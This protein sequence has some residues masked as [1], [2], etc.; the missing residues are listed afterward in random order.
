MRV[1][2]ARASWWAVVLTA[3]FA[4]AGS[5]FCD[6]SVGENHALIIGVGAYE[7]WTN[8]ES[9]PKEAR[10]LADLLTRK[11]NFKK[12]NVLL[13]TDGTENLPTRNRISQA[14]GHYLQ[15]MGPK[16]NLLVFF[17]GRS[18]TN[19]TGQTYW[20]P[21]DA[22]TTSTLNWL[23][24]A[25]LVNEYF[26]SPRFAAKNVLIITDSP[27]SAEL[28]QKGDNPLSVLNL[29][30]GERV[31]E[32]ASRK[33]REVIASGI[34]H[35]DGASSPDGMSP[36]VRALLASLAENTLEVA[37]LENLLFAPAG[38]G[39]ETAQVP[40]VRGRLKTAA[41]AGGQF[42]VINAGLYPTVDVVR[43][44][45]HP[46]EGFPGTVFVFKAET[47]KP[48]RSVAL[49]INGQSIPMKG[50]GTLWTL[51]TPIEEIQETT[52]TARALNRLDRPGQ[53][54]EALLKVVK[55]PANVIEIVNLQVSPDKV[56]P[57]GE[58]MVTITTRSPA[59][60]LALTVDGKPVDAQGGGMDW[61]ARIK[62]DKAGKKEILARAVNEDGLE[63]PLARTDLTVSAPLVHVQKVAIRPSTGTVGKPVTISARTDKP[64]SRVV[65]WIN[66]RQADM[67]GSGTSWKYSFVPFRA[68][69]ASVRVAAANAG[70]EWGQEKTTRFSARRAYTP[71]SVTQVRAEPSPAYA[72]DPVNV[73]ANTSS[74]ASRVTVTVDGRTLD[75][76]GGPTRW[77]Q[78]VILPAPGT[79]K[80]TFKA[81]GKGGR[82]GAP[83]TLS[84]VVEKKSLGE[85]MISSV[86]V[87]PRKVP[88]GKPV[89]FVMITNRP[90]QAA[91]IS[92]DGGAPV[93]MA[94][95]NGTIWTLDRAFD[96]LGTKSYVITAVDENGE[97]AAP[98]DGALL[99]KA[100]LVQITQSFLEPDVIYAGG[101]LT[102]IALTDRDAAGV[103]VK[104]NGQVF[105]MTGTGREWRYDTKV[106]VDGPDTMTIFIQ[107]KNEE[108]RYGAP[109]IWDITK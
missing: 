65:V 67:K 18:R 33:S 58:A 23:K 99:V 102:I 27:F 107:A 73:Y 20:I 81:H 5:G 76:D 106:P 105:P 30:Y 97:T 55:E 26:A 48:A 50:E 78:S 22:G 24:H 104:I 88:K 70:G 14:L 87:S 59:S 17:S 44:S 100:P 16:D 75:M 68:G 79:A 2:S 37:D 31:L 52:V 43:L 4:W 42:V 84:L 109:K 69:S 74:A 63:G 71:P 95:D 90:A 45:V 7:E 93:A 10:A 25:D 39:A 83:K 6:T 108:G 80:L 53:A 15:T 86:K 101:D 94:S 72:G 60:A 12:Q 103:D 66:G 28:L 21:S 77:S 92:F 29:R 36:F 11:Y 8:L 54:A 40:F 9:P 41:E 3:L 19:D 51:E 91:Q 46:E 13:L 35:A 38:I 1:F 34:P 82:S 62:P 49:T 96:D 32:K 98:V 47:E 56:F 85:L 61:F 57:G 64:A 89:S